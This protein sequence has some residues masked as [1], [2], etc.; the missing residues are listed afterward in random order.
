MKNYANIRIEVVTDKSIQFLETLRDDIGLSRIYHELIIPQDYQCPNNS[1]FKARAL[2]WGAK[3]S[4][5]HENAYILHLDEESI[6]DEDL[7][8]GVRQFI[9]IYKGYIGQGI[10]TYS[11]EYF[12]C[13]GF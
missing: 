9:S 8:L 3:K 7:Y 2:E 4:H 1:L 13:R 12:E 6:I 5:C 11:G 10:I